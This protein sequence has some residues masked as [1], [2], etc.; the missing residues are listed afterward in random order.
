MKPKSAAILKH[1][2]D[3]LLVTFLAATVILLVGMLRSHILRN[4]S[5]GVRK[6]SFRF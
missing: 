1:I 4:S 6:L 5:F 3:S 2:I